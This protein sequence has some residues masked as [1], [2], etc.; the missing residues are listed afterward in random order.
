MKWKP[1]QKQLLEDICVGPL[2][3]AAELEAVGSFEVPAKGKKGT[4]A[5]LF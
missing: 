2:F 1:K 3:S 5:T 4:A